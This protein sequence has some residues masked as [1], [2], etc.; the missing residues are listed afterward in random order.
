MPERRLHIMHVLTSFE[1]GGLENGV[2]NVINRS[3]PTKF[4]HSVCCL[5]RSGASAKQIRRPDV[6]IHALHKRAGLDWGI[7]RRLY[8]VFRT[9]HVDIVHTRN[10][11]ALDAILPARL[12]GVPV[13]IHGEHGRDASDPDGR[14]ALRR[15][16]RRLLAPW[17]DHFVAVSQDL[18]DWLRSDV[19]I[20]S[21]KLLCLYNG[22][23][24]DRFHPRPASGGEPLVVGTVARLDPIK[25][26]TI[27]IRAVKTLRE[28][29]VDVKLLIV[30]DGPSR[31]QL[32]SLVDE[33]DLTESVDLVG[34]QQHSAPWYHHMDIFVLPSLREGL[35]NTIL[36]AMASGLPVVATNV[37]GNPELVKHEETGLLIP[38]D[39]L[40][41]L[42]HAIRRYHDDPRLRA[43][44]GEQGAGRARRRFGLDH[45]IAGY[46]RLYLDQA[47]Q[48]SLLSR[49]S[50]LRNKA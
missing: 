3:D 26:Q 32:E 17:I 29:G 38:V 48:H 46:E 19:G 1:K 24:L 2:V 39:D 22:V 20:P 8:R 40:E 4:R 33:L 44:H 5:Q 21:R 14:R 42:V 9:Q 23:D 16:V 11:G 31:A 41:A 10:W 12:A 43:V 30:G 49:S 35:S 6:V 18:C 15:V 37:G 28:Q 50:S 36:E 47:R 27:L 45:M 7:F 13:I 25:H 34:E